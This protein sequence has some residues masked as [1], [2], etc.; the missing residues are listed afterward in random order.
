MVFS[1]AWV[2]Y[3]IILYQKKLKSK[4]RNSIKVIA[5]DCP[6]SRNLNGHLVIWSK[7]SLMYVHVMHFN[8]FVENIVIPIEFKEICKAQSPSSISMDYII[9]FKKF[10][11]FK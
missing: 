7:A 8:H 5:K 2:Q 10:K 6:E 3:K 1:S 9:R 4:L 11:H